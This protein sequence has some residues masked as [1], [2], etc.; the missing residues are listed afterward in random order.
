MR[1]KTP[2][3]SDTLWL[4]LILLLLP[5]F[6]QL[7]HIRPLIEDPLKCYAVCSTVAEEE[8]ELHN[9]SSKVYN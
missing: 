1:A 8:E 9:L 6:W 7:M 2:Q 4:L 3:A 5:I